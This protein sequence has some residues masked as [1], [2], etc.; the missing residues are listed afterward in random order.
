ME[1]KK[2]KKEGGHIKFHKET[3]HQEP[4]MGGD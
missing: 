2:K 1:K 3:Y 4:V